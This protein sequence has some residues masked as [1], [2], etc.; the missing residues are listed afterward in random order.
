MRLQESGKFQEL[1]EDEAAEGKS[2]QGEHSDQC[3]GDME[4][5][6][7]ENDEGLQ[8]I[9]SFQNPD[10][11]ESSDTLKAPETDSEDDKTVEKQAGD[12]LGAL[13][14]DSTVAA[15]LKGAADRTDT[16]S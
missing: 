7:D 9:S 13:T 11:G 4:D 3:S 6:S 15:N 12:G 2:W 10:T 14:L 1:E 5:D 16:K 8:G